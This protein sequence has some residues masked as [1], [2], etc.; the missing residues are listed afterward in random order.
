VESF[1]EGKNCIPDR[2]G[3]ERE[4]F[5]VMGGCLGW[6]FMSC[7]ECEQVSHLPSVSLT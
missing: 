2:S 3:R 7:G 4:E 5:L 1:P 6:Q